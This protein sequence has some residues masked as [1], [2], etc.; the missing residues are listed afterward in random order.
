MEL[1]FIILYYALKEKK[2]ALEVFKDTDIEFYDHRLQLFYSVLAKHF[3]DP[4]IREV[5][6]KTAVVSYATTDLSPDQAKRFEVIYE[7][8]EA[9]KIGGESP[10]EVDFRYYLKRLKD[11][12]N[13]Q[14]ARERQAALEELLKAKPTSEDIMGLFQAAVKD[15]SALNAIQVF[16][17]GTVGADVAN[18]LEEYEVIAKDPTPFRG[19]LTGFESFDI[20]SNGFQKGELIVICGLEGSGKSL[21][22]MNMGINAW[23]GTN[24][25]D[26]N[27][28][29]HNGNNI[30]YFTLEM[31][32]SNKGEF[33]QGAYLNKRILS[34]VADVSFQDLRNGRLSPVEYDRLQKATKF[35]DQ[36]E[37]DH[38]KF[39]VIDIPRG[40]K[41]EDIEA[42]YLEV[43]E[44]MDIDLVIIDY[45]GI[46]AADSDVPDHLSQGTIAAGIHELARTY[47]VPFLTAAQL[48]R[49]T[50]Q[51]KQSLDGQSFN[52]TRIARSAMIGQNANIVMIIETRDDEELEDEMIVHIT[53]MRDGERKR[54]VFTKLFHRMRIID[55]APVSADDPETADFE[56]IGEGFIQRDENE[57]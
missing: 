27:Q 48:N 17:E 36:Y 46:M 5:L 57:I 44:Q 45:L 14:I 52:N 47:N 38:N 54:L 18:M 53:K 37:Q 39:H 21:L 4:T 20:L 8:A 43:K 26:T 19:V 25:L 33:T 9:L 32:R 34:S 29:A 40:A 55:G 10:P 30:L 49:P 3:N 22:M 51:R 50:G 23:L 41:V 56:D 2:Y 7:K 1:D 24:T 11:R 15:L 35:I 28:I 13:V 42:K 6:S 31:P 16:D 12:R